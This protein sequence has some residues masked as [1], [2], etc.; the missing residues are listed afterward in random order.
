V[1][2]QINCDRCKRFMKFV[3]KKELKVMEDYLLCKVC[4]ETET[5]LQKEV[6]QIKTR[7][8]NDFTQKANKYKALIDEIIS[9][10]IAEEE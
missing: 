1:A 6:E 5:K 8:I 2:I 10:R 9:K 3:S 7:A 4:M